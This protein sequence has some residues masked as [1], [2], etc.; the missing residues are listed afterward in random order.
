M[1]ITELAIKRPPLIIV[2]FTVL[3][4]LGGF[5]YLQ[6]KY[7]LIPNMFPPYVTVVTVYPGA[8]PQ[9][10]ESSVTKPIED[11]VAGV[12]RIKK[13]NSYSYEN[14]SIVQTE[15]QFTADPTKANQDV[16]K[17]VNE[18]IASL[19]PSVKTPTVSNFSLD[20]FPIIRIGVTADMD[21]R[22][23]YQIVKDNV[24][25]RLSRIAGVAQVSIVGGQE[26]EVRVN[27]DLAKL[28]ASGIPVPMV[29][30]A[31]TA[32]NA[33]LP[34]GKVRDA[35]GD[36][37]VRLSGKY[38]TIDEL[39]DVAI[40]RAPG[41]AETRLGDVAD[42]EDGLKDV[43]AIGRINGKEAI[44]IVIQ[45]QSGANTV[46]VS[47]SVRSE[48]K[49]L[50][51]EFA[52]QKLAFDVAIDSSLFT[53]ESARSVMND[54]LLAIL[55]VALVM[56]AFLHSI[57]GSL[58]ILVSIPL[59]II[60]TF[61]GVYAF[62]MTLNMMTLL[63]L[64]LII[65]ILVDDSIVVL[66][67]IYRHMEM[68]KGRRVAALVG[69]NEIGFAALS[70]TMVDVAV[71]LPLSLI[72]GMIGDI[73]RQYALV[74]VMATLVSLF[75][76]FTVTP[77][78]ASRFAK[79]E[80]TKG[81][82][83]LAWFSRG[84][85]VIFLRVVAFYQRVLGW[86]L[87][88][89]IRTL[90]ATAVLVVASFALIGA[91]VVGSEFV[92]PLDQGQI[93]VAITAPMRTSIVEMNGIAARAEKSIYE[94]PEVSQVFTT[95]GKASMGWG[96][97]SSPNIAEINVTLVPAKERKRTAL[98]LS[99]Q[100]KLIVKGIPGMQVNTSPIGLFGAGDSY[101]L[102][103]T[104]RGVDRAKVQATAEKIQGAMR[105]VN[106]TGEVKLY[107]GDP[108]PV[109][110][111]RIDR[112]RLSELGLSLEGVGSQMSVA[113]S[114]YEDLKLR[115]GG[116][117]Y[118][119]RIVA[120]S[121]ERS[122]TA[123]LGRMRF[124]TSSGKTAELSQFS[125]I[126]QTYG[127]AMLQRENRLPAAEV[128]SQAIG[129]PSGD[130][131]ADIRAETKKIKLDEGVFVS[132]E[133]DAEMQTEAFTSL[134]LAILAAI[135]FVFLVMVALYNSFFYPF[136]V[137]FS[138]PVA[139]VGAIGGLALAGK[140]LNI[141]SI[142]G[143]IMLIGLVGKNAILLVDRT[144]HNRQAGMELKAALI[145]AGKTRLRPIMM[146]SFAMIFGMM[147][148]ALSA[149]GG[150]AEFKSSLGIVLIGGLTS[151]LLLT[152]LVVPAVYSLFEG[153]RN[154]F[155]RRIGADTGP[156]GEAGDESPKKEAP[157]EALVAVMS[158]RSLS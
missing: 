39:K 148:I 89:R 99:D 142:L 87:G 64:S 131:A 135:V 2:I 94:I 11:A 65:G 75:V 137:L 40:A 149:G 10:V 141:F 139:V 31:L 121:S 19:P 44:G 113:L 108:Q 102:G 117:E 151:S 20:D 50:E 66:E 57:R 93:Q 112:K 69:R 46:E 15:F 86:V 136:V 83:P 56:L 155:A 77:M 91:G 17:K 24:K 76:S 9:E 52:S 98:E 59:S 53:M 28:S 118:P 84:F 81:K 146:T 51:K 107:G 127:P 30:S 154:R 126:T 3:A 130:I 21:G 73:V 128:L 88:H 123:G 103:L 105:K 78:L 153:I 109:L 7:E 120:D 100:I 36:Y 22:E 55:L 41:G 5:S 96:G 72:S 82:H 71:F 61:I 27:L 62:G 116:S 115:T 13:V 26:R 95:V 97:E 143:V 132:E 145:E 33:D 156:S 140:T 32:A 134:G 25:A 42:V 144:L 106:G 101:S 68:G 125:E 133:G 138:I 6:L 14:Y 34:A 79:T 147:P 16:Q 90:V 23:L 104:V 37:L 150:A 12:D 54:L 114:G 111:V 35:D 74:V 43:S 63:A 1:T 80:E 45:K 60:T 29:I 157:R 58:I 85:E 129:R 70:I 122:S 4:L 18:V 119:M 67:N 47:R 8:A 110:D 158:E 48:L 152:L 124:I 49:S 92:P 38:S